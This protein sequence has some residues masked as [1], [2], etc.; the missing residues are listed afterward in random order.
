VKT[1]RSFR[2]TPMPARS[3]GPASTEAAA[4]RRSRHRRATNPITLPP[5][6]AGAAPRR[7]GGRQP[8]SRTTIAVVG[9]A[10]PGAGSGRRAKRRHCARRAPGR[11]T[12][13]AVVNCGAPGRLHHAWSSH[14][15][16]ATAYRSFQSSARAADRCR[17][18]P[19]PVVSLGSGP[20]LQGSFRDPA[21]ARLTTPPDTCLNV[22]RPRSASA[23]SARRKRA[24]ACRV[25]GS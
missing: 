18:C 11:R 19:P 20:P 23:L 24:G 4:R 3:R 14:A 15:P 21:A 25:A 13:K 10:Q 9:K 1:L 22:L 7:Q 8:A 16:E 17:G 12:I 2:D 5:R 6:R